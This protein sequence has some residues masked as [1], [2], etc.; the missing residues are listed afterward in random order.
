M[1]APLVPLAVLVAGVALRLSPAALILLLMLLVVVSSVAVMGAMHPGIVV[2]SGRLWVPGREE[3]RRAPGGNV[4]LTRLLSVKSVS[5]QGG[6]VSGRG[7]AL[8]RFLIWLQDADGGQAMVPAWGWSPKAPLQAVLRDAVVVSH[9]R[10]DPMTWVRLGFRRDEG[11]A[12]S[13]MRR[14]I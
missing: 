14:F 6:H 10:T 11:D 5:Y 8:F 1:L 3:R 7:L 4:D 2:Q 12:I 13:R 9:A